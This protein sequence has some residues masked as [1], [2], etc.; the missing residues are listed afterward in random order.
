MGAGS[1][2]TLKLREHV[3]TRPVHLTNYSL[4]VFKPPPFRSPFLGTPRG[5]D[6]TKSL[7]YPRGATV[8]PGLT[9]RQWIGA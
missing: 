1:F 2:G 3:A 4:W 5:P 6:I 7:L 8:I 9:P